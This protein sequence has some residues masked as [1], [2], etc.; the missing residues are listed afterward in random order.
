MLPS[1][2]YA[3][4]SSA[5]PLARLVIVASGIARPS[6]LEADELNVN[7]VGNSVAKA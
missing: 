6:K 1:T 3:G 7:Q 5:D 2:Q 4:L